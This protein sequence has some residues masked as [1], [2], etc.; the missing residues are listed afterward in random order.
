MNKITSNIN[1]LGGEEIDD[2]KGGRK[3]MEGGVEKRERHELYIDIP[4]PMFGIKRRL[5]D[6]KS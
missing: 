6:S 5:P 2:W 4:S 3:R 1:V